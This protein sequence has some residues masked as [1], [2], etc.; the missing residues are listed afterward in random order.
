MCRFAISYESMIPRHT[1][2][3]DSLSSGLS[4]GSDDTIKN[5]SDDN[6]DIVMDQGDHGDI[7]DKVSDMSYTIMIQSE[8]SYIIIH[9]IVR[10][11]W[12]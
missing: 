5:P 6:V 9:V 3:T 1:L 7:G 4:S 2:D 8:V 11:V 12:I 10:S